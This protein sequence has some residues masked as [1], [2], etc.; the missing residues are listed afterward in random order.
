MKQVIR[1]VDQGERNCFSIRSDSRL[2][3]NLIDFIS[4]NINVRQTEN[5]QRWGTLFKK[6]NHGDRKGN[7][8]PS[9]MLYTMV[10][11]STSTGRITN[12]EQLLEK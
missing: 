7:L 11:L 1:R 4:L 3:E 9:I 12:V 8:W 10:A 5:E 6:L 2:D